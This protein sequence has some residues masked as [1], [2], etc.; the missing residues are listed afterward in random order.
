LRASTMLVLFPRIFL[1]PN[2]KSL[3]EE[4]SGSMCG[5]FSGSHSYTEALHDPNSLTPRL[6]SGR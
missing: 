6:Q 2:S 1:L 5:G 3:A 4:L